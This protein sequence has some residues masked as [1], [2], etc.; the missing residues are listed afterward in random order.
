MKEARREVA[1]LDLTIDP[2]EHKKKEDPDINFV[3]TSVVPDF[4]Q[5]SFK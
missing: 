4:F 2:E 3:I 1:P 5:T